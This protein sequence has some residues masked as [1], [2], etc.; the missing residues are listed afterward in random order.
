M[1]VTMQGAWTVRVKAKSA[2]FQQRFKIA[3]ATVG[4]GTHP[5]TTGSPSIFVSGASWSVTIES[6]DGT[7]WKPSKERYKFPTTTLT[8]VFVDIESDDTANDGDFNDL[9][10]ECS[11]PKTESDFVVYGTVR[12]YSG[13]CILNPCFPIV[14][15]DTQ[16][17]LAQALKNPELFKAIKLLYPER[18]RPPQPN[19]P[20]PA[21]FTP[22]MIP[23]DGPRGLPERQF[24]V[25]TL[26]EEVSLGAESKKKAKAESAEAED[27]VRTVK[28]FRLASALRAGAVSLTDSIDRFGLA[29]LVGRIKLVCNTESLPGVVLRFQEY[30]RTSGELAG[31]AYTGTG[32]RETLGVATTDVSGNYVFRFTRGIADVVD[33]VLNDVGST[34]NAVVQAAPDLI[35]QLL[36]PMVPGGVSFET[37]LFTNVAPLKRINL[38]IPK[39]KC[40]VETAC[41]G[42][43]AIQAIGD[44]F[45]GAPKLG[46][47]PG[48]PPGFGPREGFNNVVSQ[49]GHVTARN[50]SGPLTECAAWN[51]RLDFFACFLDKPAVVTYTIRH[52][53][54]GT[55]TWEFYHEVL[56]HM[57][58]AKVGIPGYDGEILGPTATGLNV[59]GGG[60]IPVPAY[61]NIES[62]GSY[63][64]THRT[65]KAQF[66]SALYA[67]PPNP[68]QFWIEGYD[69]AGNKVPGAEDSITLFI[70]NSVPALDIDEDVTLGGSTKGNCALFTLPA[71]ETH[72]PLT[73]RFL[74]D[75]A[76][77]FMLTYTL[78]MQKG[79]TGTFGVVEQSPAP[80]PF[81]TRS[82]VHG[83]DFN[84]TNFRGTFDDPTHELA[85][86]YVS[87][88]LV[89]TDPS[90]WLTATQT[91][92]AFSLTLG[93]TTRRTNG[94]TANDDSPN[95]TPVLIGIQK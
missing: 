8:H 28:S 74:A 24:L 45:I 71:G 95:A 14:V 83:D 57:L 63:V 25:S 2:A 75:Q 12:C 10:L 89:P 4:N 58:V 35:A 36:D 78:G 92:C 49:D 15:I 27:R 3:G 37:A 51:R 33:E 41:Q 44:I 73:V 34:E 47:V 53:V 67:T 42:S 38:C 82:Y 30:D 85:T 69:A 76:Q 84:C 52:R 56:K 77:G 20:D 65:R 46:S 64:A 86:G 21:P 48:Q 39:G 29:S 18:V 94:V 19:P 11:T 59:D 5:G 50:T 6:N 22:L 32:A 80:P 91:F 13:L 68:V 66:T 17:Q 93:A 81:R 7:G 26:G 62:D 60:V 72:T 55:S 54:L 40:R 9:I 31:G 79:A 87:V 90:G 61:Q 70:D 23:L 1:P 88:T 16:L 43:N